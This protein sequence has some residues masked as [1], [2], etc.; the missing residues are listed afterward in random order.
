[1]KLHLHDNKPDEKGKH[2]P[3][4]PTHCADVDVDY[5]Y[6][7]EQWVIELEEEKNIVRI[8]CPD[9]G[10]EWRRNEHGKFTEITGPS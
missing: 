5:E 4:G 1:M 3:R 8:E 10:R 7:A 2:G 6:Q 9:L